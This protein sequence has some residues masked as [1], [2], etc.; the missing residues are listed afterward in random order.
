MVIKIFSEF[1]H[2][3]NNLKFY[4]ILVEIPAKIGSESAIIDP[5]W[6]LGSSFLRKYIAKLY[7]AVNLNI[8]IFY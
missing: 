4:H 3:I 8:H 1:G 2:G 6:I 7:Y 5:M